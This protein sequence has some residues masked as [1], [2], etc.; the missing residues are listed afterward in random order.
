MQFS[1]IPKSFKCRQAC[2]KCMQKISCKLTPSYAFLG[3][4]IPQRNYMCIYK[5]FMLLNDFK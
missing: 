1:L 3:D 4:F 5:I 2:E